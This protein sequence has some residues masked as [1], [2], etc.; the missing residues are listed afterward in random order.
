MGHFI[1]VNGYYMVN[2]WLLYVII[3]LMMVNNYCLVVDL[4]LE[5][6]ESQIGFIGSSSP[7]WLGKIK[8]MFQTTNQYMI[9]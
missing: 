7:I 8:K 3:W 5:T 2:I 4:P 9:L 6:Y 1:L